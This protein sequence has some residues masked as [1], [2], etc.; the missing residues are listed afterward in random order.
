MEQLPSHQRRTPGEML[1]L[2]ARCK[3]LLE[4]SSTLRARDAERFDAVKAYGC[5][6]WCVYARGAAN[7]TDGVKSV[8]ATLSILLYLSILSLMPKF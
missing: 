6:P 4:A 1:H 5:L 7:S 3:R 2:K 8:P